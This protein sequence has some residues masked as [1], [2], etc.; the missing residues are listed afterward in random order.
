MLLDPCPRRE[1]SATLS[2]AEQHLVLQSGDDIGK[3]LCLILKVLQC[4]LALLHHAL[5]LVVELLSHLV[6]FRRCSF[7]ERFKLLH[8]RVLFGLV[9][10][11]VPGNFE[12]KTSKH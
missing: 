7:F 8:G 12:L 6:L 2:F 9:L 10:R 5:Q 4:S 11:A 1:S 3:A